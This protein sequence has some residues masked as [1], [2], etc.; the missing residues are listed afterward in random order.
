MGFVKDPRTVLN[1]VPKVVHL[2]IADEPP[3]HQMSVI[4]YSMKLIEDQGYETK[5]HRDSDVTK[6]INSDYPTLVKPWETLIANEEPDRGARIGDF[7]RMLLL[8]H[9]GGIYLDADMIPC[10]GLDELTKDAGVATFPIINPKAGQVLNA[11]MSGPAQ[12]PV[13]WI[14]LSR[15]RQDKEIAGGSILGK[16]GPIMLAF[17]I[18]E[19]WDLSKTRPIV[20]VRDKGNLPEPEDGGIWLKSGLIKFGAAGRGEPHTRGMGTLGHIGMIHLHWRTWVSKGNGLF[21]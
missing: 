18:D 19:Y 5:L 21:F 6:L 17:A 14:A 13:F 1:K 3:A 8:H 15:M 2:T 4:E 10:Y 9:Y 12:H 7:A 11:I 20:R 16:T